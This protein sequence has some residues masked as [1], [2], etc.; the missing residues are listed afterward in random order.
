MKKVKSNMVK[1]KTPSLKADIPGVQVLKQAK[2]KAG[3]F[4]DGGVPAKKDG[5]AAEGTAPAANLGKAPMKKD[6]GSM[7]GRS[8]FSHASSTTP[9]ATGGKSGGY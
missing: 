1:S 5:G 2:Y 8:P 6:G 9:A 3:G 4:K 7:R